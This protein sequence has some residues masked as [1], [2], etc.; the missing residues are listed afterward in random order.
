MTKKLYTFRNVITIVIFLLLPLPLLYTFITGNTQLG[1]DK[2]TGAIFG[3]ISYTY[4]LSTLYL[5]TKPKWIDKGI[6][7]PEIY[8]IHGIIAFVGVLF[9]AIHGALMNSQGLIKYTGG[10]A[11]YLFA[12]VT[13]FSA[14][15]FASWLS[16]KFEFIKK[17]KQ[18]LESHVKHELAL[19]LHRINILSSILVFTHVSLMEPVR[20]IKPFYYIFILYAAIPLISYFIMIYRYY[21]N[22]NRATLVDLQ[23]LDDT[24]VGLTLGVNNNYARKIK[25]GDFVFIAFDEAKELAAYHPFSVVSKGK[26]TV[27]FAISEAGDF[28][29]NLK[30]LQKG[31]RARLSSGYG[32]INSLMEKTTD[33]PIVL[34]VGGI[35]ITPMISIMDNYKDKK[36]TM[37]YSVSKDKELLFTDKI[38]KWK[39]NGNYKIVAQKHRFTIE[40]ISN[41]LADFKSAYYFLAGPMRM[42]TSLK[43]DLIDAGVKADNIFFEAFNW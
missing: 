24:I 35:G 7:L 23:R 25:A 43:K 17:A 29:S 3:L 6:G 2:V 1:Q 37:L 30:S 22:P 11:A 33:Q 39:E 21:V 28:T 40:Q 12:L 41:E 8:Y 16:E 5:G 27:D 32:A 42:N 10:V 19:W 9:F 13:I 26:N 14:I 31:A 4:M 15:Y 38:E 36:I 20:S 18:Y 34:L